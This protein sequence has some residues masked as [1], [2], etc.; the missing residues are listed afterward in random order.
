[1][2]AASNGRRLPRTTVRLVCM[3]AAILVACALWVSVSQAAPLP[4]TFAA[5]A[6]ASVTPMLS[7]A[8]AL[9]CDGSGNVF[10]AWEEYGGRYLPVTDS[11][12]GA[13]S[14]APLRLVVPGADFLSFGQIRMASLG[15]GDVEMVYTAFN[16][17]FGGAEIV[18]SQ[19]TDAGETFPNVKVISA[20]DAFNSFAADIA[21]GWGIAAA[22]SNAN[23]YEGGSTIDFAVSLDEGETFSFPRR[24]DRSDGY[25]SSPALALDEDGVVYVA[26]VQNDDPFQALEAEEIFFARSSNYGQTFSIPVNVTNNAEKSWP[27][28]MAVDAQGT[29]Y[30][31]WTEG[32]FVEDE[33]LMFSVS[34]D[35]G[36]SFSMP[37]VLAGPL[38]YVEGHVVAVGSG[39]VWVAWVESAS[40]PDPFP[41]VAYLMRSS[42]SGQ[43]FSDP[44]ELPGLVYAIA[45]TR[46]GEVFA[47]WHEEPPGQ[48]V[49]D[50]Y[51]A[52]GEVDEC[53]DANL[54]GSISA[55]DALSAL[56]TAVGSGSC[57][58]CRCD[59]DSSGTIS[60]ADAL[61][62]LRA[63]VGQAVT[64]VCPAC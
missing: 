39:I 34:T 24:I 50:V 25:K 45:S 17:Q 40:S 61:A 2:T 49:A 21:V 19:S 42:D 3:G 37:R 60:A 9:A 54:D 29:I 44:V 18:Y 20:I 22:W 7:Q 59:V 43:T 4:I 48:D 46:S 36:D 31:V 52:R 6:N 11:Q 58:T 55:A 12:D 8:P 28:D 33:K 5:A 62:L 35:G 53:G 32:N 15:P 14:F 41:A 1:M 47:A 23:L 16:T 30:L 51:V 63:A 56:R 26:W 57:P 13:Q 38:G 64:L 10:V 27:P